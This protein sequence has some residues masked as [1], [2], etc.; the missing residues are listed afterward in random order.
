LDFY[1]TYQFHATLWQHQGSGGW[2]FVSLPLHLAEEIREHLQH[3]EQGWGRLPAL[4]RIGKAE[5]KTAIWYDTR[6]ATYLLPVKASIR[7]AEN[8]QTGDA[9]D[10][11]IRL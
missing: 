9:F 8:L 3:H 1:I 5:W 10:V 2:Y 7:N 4:A 6:Q 11:Q